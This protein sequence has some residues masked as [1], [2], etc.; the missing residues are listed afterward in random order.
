MAVS[1]SQ[2]IQ[3]DPLA[4]GMYVTCSVHCCIWVM[5]AT[6]HRYFFSA[7]VVDARA[8]PGSKSIVKIKTDKFKKKHIK[9]QKHRVKP[10]QPRSPGGLSDDIL[11]KYRGTSPFWPLQ[12]GKTGNI[13]YYVI[14]ERPKKWV[15][16]FLCVYSMAC[17]WCSAMHGKMIAFIYGELPSA[18]ARRLQTAADDQ[19]S[20]PGNQ[21]TQRGKRVQTSWK[22]PSFSQCIYCVCVCVC[23]KC[24]EQVGSPWELACTG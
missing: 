6:N 12:A 19:L 8:G 15:T 17:C 20:F 10:K 3:C 16:C 1:S 23:A 13:N 22:I 2:W 21:S 24:A 11:C 4:L 7:Q 5:Y 18:P 9:K 14:T